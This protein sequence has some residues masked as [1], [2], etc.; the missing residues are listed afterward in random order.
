MAPTL[1]DPQAPTVRRPAPDHAA[2]AER[3][4]FADHEPLS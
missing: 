4:S 2:E 1:S 3:P